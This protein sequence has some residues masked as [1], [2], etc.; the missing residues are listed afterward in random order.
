MLWVVSRK[1]N[2]F[3]NHGAFLLLLKVRKSRSGMGLGKGL[4]PSE[5][6]GS[7]YLKGCD[8]H[9]AHFQYRLSRGLFQN[10]QMP[11][12]FS[13]PTQRCGARV[14]TASC[15]G[16]APTSPHIA[17]QASRA[18]LSLGTA[19]LPKS[20]QL[21]PHWAGH[22]R[23]WGALCTAQHVLARLQHQ[24]AL[25]CTTGVSMGSHHPLLG[26]RR[27]VQDGPRAIAITCPELGSGRS[28]PGSP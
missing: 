19:R 12:C 24:P 20:C 13:A 21:L 27:P 8:W 5:W 28:G 14:P 1:D 15:L 4:P 26:A 7:G 6:F 18:G 3:S 2:A 11:C 23:S 25:S 17:L 10:T 22:H 9:Q 16:T